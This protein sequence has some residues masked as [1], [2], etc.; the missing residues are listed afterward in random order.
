ML[1]MPASILVMMCTVTSAVCSAGEHDQDFEA[2]CA[3]FL[4]TGKSPYRGASPLLR[5]SPAENGTS[6]VVGSPPPTDITEGALVP[7]AFPPRLT[8]SYHGCATA[9]PLALCF[10]GEQQTI[11]VSSPGQHD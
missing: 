3:D 2:F 1:R 6:L 11:S 7:V 4:S 5:L 9:S 8:T 10:D